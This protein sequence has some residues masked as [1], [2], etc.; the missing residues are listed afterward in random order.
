LKA[1]ATAF[2]T[3]VEA[4]KLDGTYVDRAAGRQTFRAYAEQWRLDQV[5]YAKNTGSLVDSHLRNHIY[6]AFG[7]R[8]IGSIRTSHVQAWIRERSKPLGSLSPRTVEAVYTRLASILKAAVGDKVIST[9]PCTEQVKLP[10]IIDAPVVP[11]PVDAVSALAEDVPER[12]RALVVVG[13][14]LGLRQGEAFGLRLDHIDFL[15]RTV[16]IDQQVILPESGPPEIGPLKTSASY[17]TLPLPD[18]VGEALAR[19][20]AR[21][22]PG[23]F[24]LIFANENGEAIRRN[25]FND[26]VLE[27]AVKRLKF[28]ATFHDL[29]HFYASA[30]IFAGQSVK[31]V[32]ARLGHKSAMVTLD[33][34]GH[35]WPNDEDGSRKAIDGLFT[36]STDDAVSNRC[37]G[38]PPLT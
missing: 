15:R 32:Q 29:R 4:S 1:E 33:T 10:K 17:R 34:Y 26:G 25:R 7:D 27:P 30:L 3:M 28:E 13:F 8:P 12:Y 11:L 9:S 18:V 21:F 5:H 31:V 19:H 14:G 36:R 24:G 22:K 35:L 16:R 20:L 38:A 2:L 37:Q 23:Q 6:P